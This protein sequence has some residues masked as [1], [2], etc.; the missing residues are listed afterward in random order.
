MRFRRA[1]AAVAAACWGGSIFIVAAQ[2]VGEA[3][4]DAWSGVRIL[5]MMA[6]AVLSLTW[7]IDRYVVTPRSAYRIGFEAG[8]RHARGTGQGDLV[9]FPAARNGHRSPSIR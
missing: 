8:E 4:T 2:F 7:V 1:A 9:Q 6:A 5:L 3:D